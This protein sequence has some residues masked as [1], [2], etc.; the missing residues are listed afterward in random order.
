MNNYGPNYALNLTFGDTDKID[1]IK[2]NI[3][4]VPRTTN[5]TQSGYSMYK[6]DFAKAN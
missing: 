1:F 5:A 3:K 2:E 6:S 4:Y